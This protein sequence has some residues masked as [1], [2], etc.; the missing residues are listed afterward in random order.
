MLPAPVPAAGSPP[1]SGTAVLVA[2]RIF[3][4]FGPTLA[5]D[6]VS[7]GLVPGEIHAIL[8]ENGAGKSTLLAVLSGMERPDAGDIMVD[9]RVVRFDGPGV[10]SGR[11]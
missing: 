8:G 11:A 5:N 4:C 10:P 7:L 3:K 9:G 1:D 2:R 6:D